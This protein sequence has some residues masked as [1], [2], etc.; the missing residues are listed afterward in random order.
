MHE[1][2]DEFHK[3]QNEA[4]KRQCADLF[5]DVSDPRAAHSAL[6][7]DA[8]LSMQYLGLVLG[9]ASPTCA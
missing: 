4:L 6:C 3:L 9:A 2:R 8:Q 1:L 7:S 5:L